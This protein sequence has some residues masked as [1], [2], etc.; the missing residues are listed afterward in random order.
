MRI[1]AQAASSASGLEF[2]RSLVAE[3]KYDTY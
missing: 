3:S 2:I 1:A